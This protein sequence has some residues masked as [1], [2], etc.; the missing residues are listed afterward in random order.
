MLISCKFS[1][2]CL[3]HTVFTK[4]YAPISKFAVAFVI[5]KMSI[6]PYPPAYFTV[7]QCHWSNPEEY[8]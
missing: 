6:Y 3:R 5:R 8:G 1:A 2:V 7:T 4:K